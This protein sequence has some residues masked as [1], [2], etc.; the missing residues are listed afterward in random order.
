MGGGKAWLS[1]GVFRNERKPRNFL[2]FR[3]G[4][5]GRVQGHGVQ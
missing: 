5:E 4:A 2:G 1:L 3:G